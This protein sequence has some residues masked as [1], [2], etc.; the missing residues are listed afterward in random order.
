M[1]VLHDKQGRSG[2]AQ[3]SAKPVEKLVEYR[4][5]H[6]AAH[7]EAA[8][9]YTNTPARVQF[10]F[11]NPIICELKSGFK[12]M[13]VGGGDAFEF[14]PGDAMYVPPGMEIDI[15][16]GT[17]REDAPIE[18]DCVEV[19]TGRVDG[20]LA[21]L[22]ESLSKGG[23]EA[24]AGIDWSAYAVLRGTDA[25]ELHLSR[26]MK[27]FRGER[28]I[29]SDLRI[30]AR[31]DDTLLR[32]LQSRSRD[33]LMMEEGTVDSGLRAVVRLIRDNLHRQIPVE[34]L[35]RVACM[36][37]STLH[38]SF[39]KS[40]GTTPAR[41]ATQMRVSEAKEKLRKSDTPLE[42]LAYDLGFA[43]ASHFGR[44]FR[45]T[46]AESPAEYRRRRQRPANMRDW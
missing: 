7:S 38:R 9:Y 6:Y 25:R 19:E 35:A 4:K 13:R 36:S 10:R 14:R 18:C 3:P 39:R 2:H 1:T 34:E 46:T 44:V 12:V 23:S 30:D 21:R 31:L 22:N 16:L 20:I 45:K 26:L 29:F 5:A 24:T 40:F 28:D 8:S 42:T 11:A 43:D 17:A 15:D 41:F 27:L 37:E 33:L 32:L